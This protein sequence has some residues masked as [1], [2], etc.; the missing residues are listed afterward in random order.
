NMVIGC[1]SWTAAVGTVDV[2][3]WFS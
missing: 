1:S 3:G 2:I